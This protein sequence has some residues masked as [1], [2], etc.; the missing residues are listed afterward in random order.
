VR[1]ALSTPLYYADKSLANTAALIVAVVSEKVGRDPD[2]DGVTTFDVTTVFQQSQK[3][4]NVSRF[5]IYSL[6]ST[7]RA[8]I[9]RQQIW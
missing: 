6:D 1:I 4:I 9:F 8:H 7:N 5:S 3:E 2:S